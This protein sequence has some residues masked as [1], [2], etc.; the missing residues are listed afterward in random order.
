MSKGDK[1]LLH[2][3]QRSSQ[4]A[5]ELIR[6]GEN[7]NLA[8]IS[9]YQT[10]YLKTILHNL[11]LVGESNIVGAAKLHFDNA[12]MV[13]HEK[14]LKKMEEMTNMLEDFEKRANSRPQKFKTVLLD[15][16]NRTLE[17]WNKDFDQHLTEFGELLKQTFSR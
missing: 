14:L 12:K 3:D 4:E 17:Q 13:L 5:L 11:T 2:I 10:R 16:A 9:D 15:A 7:N 1:E 6:K 8:A